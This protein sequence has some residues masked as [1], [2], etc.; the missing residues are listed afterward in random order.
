MRKTKLTV[1]LL[2][3][4][5]VL[6]GCANGTVAGLGLEKTDGFENH[7]DD[8]VIA[9][10]V[11][12]EDGTEGSGTATVF[13]DQ[14]PFDNNEFKVDSE[15]TF[16]TLVKDADTSYNGH[17]YYVTVKGKNPSDI[18]KCEIKSTGVAEPLHPNEAEGIGS[19]TCVLEVK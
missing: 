13:E 7:R 12:N 2:G 11:E 8:I 9:A 3:S 19:A 5:A 6:A 4:V 18:V 16:Y 1:A 17:L 15:E 10:T 14:A